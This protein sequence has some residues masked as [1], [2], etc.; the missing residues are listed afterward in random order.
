[1]SDARD[2]W[3]NIAKAIGF[4][5]AGT[6]GVVVLLSFSEG[7]RDGYSSAQ[8]SGG[9]TPAEEH[10]GASAESDS[11]ANGDDGG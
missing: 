11:G 6:V 5:L 3:I 2:T 10:A 7:F 4:V 8:R 1:M 9:E